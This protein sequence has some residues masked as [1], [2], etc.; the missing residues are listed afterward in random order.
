MRFLTIVIKLNAVLSVVVILLTKSLTVAYAVV[1]DVV[2]QFNCRYTACRLVRRCVMLLS[3]AMSEDII[4]MDISALS[5]VLAPVAESDGPYLRFRRRT[6]SL[7]RATY[8]ASAGAM[9]AMDPVVV[10]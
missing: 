2:D 5:G 4:S 1:V 9:S 3:T 8:S 10:F 6:V 7:E